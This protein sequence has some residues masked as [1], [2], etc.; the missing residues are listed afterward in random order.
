MGT[1]AV[2][3]AHPFAV[4]SL[5]RLRNFQ[6]ARFEHQRPTWLDEA[7]QDLGW[8]VVRRTV[9]GA[10]WVAAGVRGRRRCERC[11]VLVPAA[12]VI[13]VVRPEDLVTTHRWCGHPRAAIIPAIGTLPAAAAVMRAHVPAAAWGPVGSVALELAS[14]HP[15]TTPT[16]D[17]DLM[18]KVEEPL[19]RA[20]AVAL[21]DAFAAL[22][23][24]VDLLL[25]T[26]YGALALHEYAYRPS[27]WLQRTPAGPRLTA[28]PWPL[29]CGE[30]D[31]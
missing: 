18:L 15:W 16:S 4:H 5:L 25:E 22:G 12:A 29:S 19:S 28:A 24:R 9:A 7:P 13:D 17:L 6:A 3:G 31:V 10:G 11:A 8:V 27:P 26:P 23:V 2:F 20:T 30:R 1:D 21:A 14:T